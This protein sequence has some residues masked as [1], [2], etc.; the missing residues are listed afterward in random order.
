MHRSVLT[1]SHTLLRMVFVSITTVTI[2]TSVK[3]KLRYRYGY[4]VVSV[5]EFIIV[6]TGII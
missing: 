5:K 4:D 3:N 6:A 2:A 1:T